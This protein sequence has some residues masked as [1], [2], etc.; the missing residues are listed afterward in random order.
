M[1]IQWNTDETFD[2]ANRHE[3]IDLETGLPLPMEPPWN[4]VFYADDE[5]G[6]VRLFIRGDQGDVLVAFE[7]DPQTPVLGNLGPAKYDVDG[8]IL[9]PICTAW[10]EEKKAIKIVRK[11][12][13]IR[14]CN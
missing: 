6:V 14:S 13:V 2:E 7:S 4:D 11:S 1:I 10:R 3:I 8:K 12:E 5:A 9:N